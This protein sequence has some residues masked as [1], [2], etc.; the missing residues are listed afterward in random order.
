MATPPVGQ[1]PR[2][3]HSKPASKDGAPA[4][5]EELPRLFQ[6][7]DTVSSRSS[8]ETSSTA[9]SAVPAGPS[10]PT[11]SSVMPGSIHNDLPPPIFVDMG[12]PAADTGDVWPRRAPVASGPVYD[13]IPPAVFV[14]TGVIPAYG[15]GRIGPIR[16]P[17]VQQQQVQQQRV[18]LP[19]EGSPGVFA[20]PWQ[21]VG[22][23]SQQHAAPQMVRANY[24]RVQPQVAPPRFGAPVAPHVAPRRGGFVQFLLAAIRF[25][26]R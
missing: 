17:Q 13:G 1:S 15:R 8:S 22:A 20:T 21:A 11:R 7:A 14:D 2:I 12:V 4:R 18:W 19:V 3:S 10:R 26:F 9:S 6:A 16:P 24:D 25:F 23:Q 5:R